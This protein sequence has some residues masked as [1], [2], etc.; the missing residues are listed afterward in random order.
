M[1]V[2]RMK[3]RLKS[4][5][6]SFSELEGEGKPKLSFRKMTD[7][8]K[9]C[10]YKQQNGKIFKVKYLFKTSLDFVM[11]CKFATNKKILLVLNFHLRCISMCQINCGKVARW[12]PEGVLLDTAEWK[13]NLFPVSEY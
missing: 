9:Y 10:T 3:K 8:R 1:S 13:V 11:L 12:N 5:S 6:D 7:S 4:S 2:K